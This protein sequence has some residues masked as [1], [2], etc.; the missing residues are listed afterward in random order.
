M[1]PPCPL[2]GSKSTRTEPRR[3]ASC[4]GRPQEEAGA[5]LSPPLWPHRTRGQRRASLVALLALLGS[6]LRWPWSSMV[7]CPSASKKQ[8]QAAH[9]SPRRFIPKQTT[10]RTVFG[11]GF[12]PIS[13]SLY[14]GLFSSHNLHFG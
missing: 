8:L 14:T 12:S 2:K 9:A 7:T 1:K 6:S 11:K 4:G 10:F 5:L 3:A 13:T